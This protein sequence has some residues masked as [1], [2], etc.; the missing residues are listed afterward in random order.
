MSVLRALNEM[1]I[2]EYTTQS[3][4]VVF[5]SSDKKTFLFPLLAQRLVERLRNVTSTSLNSESLYQIYQQE[6]DDIDQF[7]SLLGSLVRAGLV[8]RPE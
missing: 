1:N 6:F 7:E 2:E 4:W 3:N 5:V 8:Q